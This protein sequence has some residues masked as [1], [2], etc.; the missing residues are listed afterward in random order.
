MARIKD[1]VK[2]LIVKNLSKRLDKEKQ[3]LY[4]M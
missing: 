3:K 1:K 2:R 4:I